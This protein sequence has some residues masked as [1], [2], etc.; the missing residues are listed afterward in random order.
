SGTIPRYITKKDLVDV[1]KVVLGSEL[2][3][4]I[5]LFTVT[6]LEGIP[7]SVPAI[8]ALI[9]GVGLVT[10]RALADFVDRR[11]T[12]DQPGSVAFEN[13]IFILLNDWSVVLM[14]FLQAHTRGGWR[15]IALLAEERRWIGRAVSG[16]RVFGPPAYLDTVIEE[17]A[18]HGLRTD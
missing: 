8:H 1:T 2:M 9:L 6:R 15:V 3:T 12:A 11:R 18:T 10:A 5:A 14:K 7:R 4:A 17:F 13:V 16:V